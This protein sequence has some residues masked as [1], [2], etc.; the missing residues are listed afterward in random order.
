MCH[1]KFVTFSRTKVELN[2]MKPS[3][4]P[5]LLNQSL[6]SHTQALCDC[7]IACGKITFQSGVKLGLFFL[8]I[9]TITSKINQSEIDDEKLFYP[10]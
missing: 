8:L 5:V 6:K 10:Y 4:H 1:V 2:R 9:F 3:S 7:D